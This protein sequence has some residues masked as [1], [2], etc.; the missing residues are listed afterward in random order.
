MCQGN[1]IS[2]SH[3]EAARGDPGWEDPKESRVRIG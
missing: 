2:K 3:L 1:T